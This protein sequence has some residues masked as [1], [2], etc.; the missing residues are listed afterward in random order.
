MATSSSDC[1][2]FTSEYD[3]FTKLPTQVNIESTNLVE[4]KSK[5]SLQD[6]GPL[7]FSIPG[8]V[9]NIDFS[10]SYLDMVVKVTK[11]DGTNIIPNPPAPRA[12]QD[13][14]NPEFA[15][16][17]NLFMHSLFKNVVLEIGGQIISDT[18]N[19]YPYRSYLE[20]LLHYGRDAKA[21]HLQE[22]LYYKDTIPELINDDNEGL[23]K[24]RNL[25]KE[26][27]KL[28]LKGRLHLDMFQ[29]SKVLMDHTEVKLRLVRHDP[30]FALVTQNI[31]CK[32]KIE[33][34]SFFVC[35]H[36]PTP[37]AWSAILKEN[38]KTNARY[39]IKRVVV[40]N[41]QISQG[42]YQINRDDIFLGTVPAVMVFGIVDSAAYSGSYGKNPFNFEHCYM[43]SATV[44]ISGQPATVQSYNFD[45]ENNRFLD[46]YHSLFEG[47][48]I[49]YTNS[50]IDIERDNYPSGYAL[51]Q[52]DLTKSM[53]NYAMMKDSSN[54]GDVRLEIKF[55]RPL[56]NSMV[57][58]VMGIHLNEL[59]ITNKREVLTDYRT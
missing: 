34:A 36:R 16:P 48:A 37:T 29:Q 1:V 2:C 14:A 41:Y 52:C 53:S 20:T 21:S 58:I 3:L 30:E 38:Q 28:Q 7:E 24:R 15:G 54:K 27:K 31:A 35:K 44:S 26:G 6:G 43:T 22:A 9:D 51:I 47:S 8:S 42:D 11:V 50:G 12:G 18:S 40:K 56:A 13:A 19:N 45:F 4:Y 5:T 49:G 10:K 32:I 57:L 55:G 33:E 39:P 46:G 25:I 17:V 59:E 23:K